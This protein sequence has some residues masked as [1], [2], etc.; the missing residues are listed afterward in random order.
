MLTSK[1][2]FKKTK[3]GGVTKINRE[4][5]LR[6]DIACGSVLCDKCGRLGGKP[7][8][9]KSTSVLNLD[10]QNLNIHHY[11]I[12]DTNVVMHQ[13]DILEDAFITNVIILQTVIEEV[14][15]HNIAAYKRLQE[16]ICNP[17]KSF[18]VF[19]NEF[20]QATY[21][22]RKP[23]ES[24]NDR[25]DRAIR[26][27]TKWYQDHMDNTGN[28][29]DKIKMV[30]LSDDKENR[31]RAEEDGLLAYT[32]KY[33]VRNLQDATH[34]LDKLAAYEDHE[35]S[36]GKNLFPEHLSFS[37]INKGVKFGKYMQG[38]FQA[39]RENYLEGRV[40]V[41]GGDE[42]V[43]IVGR[44]NLNRAVQDD[45]V[46]IEMLPE[47]EWTCP[48]SLIMENTVD[49]E[50]E[51][52]V[53]EEIKKKAIPK[54]K[55][56]PTGRVVGIIRPNRRNYCG[57]LKLSDR[58]ESR[59]HLFIPANKQIPKIYIRTEQGKEL[60]GQR[61]IVAIDKWP[62]HSRYPLGHFVKKL[63]PIGNKDTENEV[64]LLEHDVPHTDFCQRVLECLPKLPWIINEEDLK[65][66]ED[67]RHLN[68]CSVDPPGCTDIDDALHC[69]ML[70]NGNYEV[71]VHI[72]DVSHFIRPGTALDDEAKHRA[73][74]VYLTDQRIDMVPE[75]LSSNLCSL[76]D[77]GD[78]FAFSVIWEIDNDAKILSTKFHKSVIRSKASLTYQ[79]AQNR[80]DSSS[81]D[82]L[83]QSLRGLNK[84][85]K[86]LK[87][88]R[89]EN[90]ALV[91]ASSEIRFR[92]DSATHEPID[93]QAK[94]IRDTNSM[95]EEFMLLGN[96]SAAKKIFESFPNCA[97]LRRHPAPPASNF[98][99][100][101][102]AAASRGVAMDCTTSKSLA[103]SLDNADFGCNDNANTMLRMM[104]TRCM[105]QAVYFSS[106]TLQ[107]QE[108]FHYGLAAAI[109]THF[110]SPIRRYPDILVH[111]L[112]ALAIG[113]DSSYPDLLENQK[114]Q[115]TCNHCNYR[116]KMAQDASRSSVNLHTH[117]FFKDKK[118]DEDGYILFV[119]KNAIQ[120]LIPKYGLE[121]TIYVTKSSKEKSSIFTFDEEKYH[122]IAGDIVLK[123]FDHVTV[124]VYIDRS[125]VQ[126]MKL[127]LDLVEPKI[128]GFSVPPVSE[129]VDKSSDSN[130]EPATKKRKTV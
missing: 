20:H 46:A 124:Q 78:R 71:G 7:V 130:D 108:F 50:K 72:A 68:I 53:E 47:E 70:E 34:L 45:T 94:E 128:P 26:Q 69:R 43:L 56:Q 66:R 39:S 87:K 11:L 16:M 23:A 95:V 42:M 19:S 122:M 6:D 30:L 37:E 88:N 89:I 77:D 1:T 57:I 127:H 80:I 33:Y 5:Y 100:L 91:L 79:E 113:A 15:N 24:S 104:T 111:R 86:I 10:D 120:V 81:Q 14:K 64:L 126:H 54:E 13:L 115:N 75:L 118:C 49:V 18:Y 74:T 40:S 105:M 63:G 36:A 61:I 82:E 4:H 97:V 28:T 125:N 99:P 96:V 98:K 35:K 121:G 114:M 92:I 110:T 116:H 25:N 59:N 103:E 123:V 117:I 58:K 22:E 93:V 84:L 17:A 101:I 9:E 2:F 8:L 44:E 60:A 21:I 31:T 3:K 62:I 32:V 85:A 38:K 73:T 90:G 129:N 102:Q 65:R 106:G 55:R 119:R 41:V 52:E 109:Y 29:K 67:I 83:T 76:R 48:T 51:D 12:P 27:A 107:E 112:L